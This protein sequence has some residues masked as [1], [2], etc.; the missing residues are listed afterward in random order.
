MQH[1]CILALY[2]ATLLNSFINSN[3]FL[4]ASL[5]FSIYRV[6]S[7]ANRDSFIYF[8]PIWIP[9][10]SVSCLTAIPRISNTMLNKSN[11][12]RH[13]ELVSDL[14]GNTFSLSPLRWY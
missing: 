4:V 10:I 13:S 9:F 8:F 11:E 1:F 6:M 3:R 2:P 7:Y 5:G 12:S 14:R